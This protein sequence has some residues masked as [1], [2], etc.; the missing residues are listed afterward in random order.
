[1]KIRLT[2]K[3]RKLAESLEIPEHVRAKFY[4]IFNDP[5]EFRVYYKNIEDFKMENK[6]LFTT[7]VGSQLFKMNHPGSDIDYFSVYI[8]PT[9]DILRGINRGGGSHCGKE[10]GNDKA[11]HEIGMVIEK[12][13]KGDINCLMG[14]LSPLVQ[15][16]Y[17]G[18][19]IE[20]STLVEQHCKT[21]VCADSIRGLAIHNYKKY[22]VGSD[23]SK[24]YDITKK[25]GLIVRS[26][27]FGINIFRGAGFRFEPVFNQTP[28][29]VKIMLKTFDIALL[30]SYI[31]DTTPEEPF[32]DF[33]E[34]L[35]LEDLK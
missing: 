19:L 17:K 20:L 31:P 12:L 4:S 15:Y 13:I 7:I 28:D 2:E 21:K 34:K 8:V 10:K 9:R 5:N 35:R 27:L 6:I 32:R 3:G 18:T 24:E 14:I 26:L 29:D 11:S 1:M 30:D 16:D 23:T 22:I 25:C 33:L